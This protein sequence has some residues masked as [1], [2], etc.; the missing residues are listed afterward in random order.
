[1][2]EP[3][4][5]SRKDEMLE[6]IVKAIEGKEIQGIEIT[7]TDTNQNKWLFK[8]AETI[9]NSGV[10]GN[11]IVSISSTDKDNPVQLRNLESGVYVLHGYFN[12]CE[13]VTKVLV[14]QT[15]IYASVGKSTSKSYIQ[16]FFPLNNTIQYF[17][18]TDTDYIMDSVALK[19]TNLK[20]N[21]KTIVGAINEIYDMVSGT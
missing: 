1:M 16:L 17:E 8:I 9:K 7:I 5:Y 21:N 19:Q 15:P 11:G 14:A 13:A 12:P 2:E 6:Q 3:R 4:V 10:G 18:I 20:T